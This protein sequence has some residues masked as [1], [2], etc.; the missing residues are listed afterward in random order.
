MLHRVTALG[1]AP[2]LLAQGLYVRRTIPRLPEPTCPREGVDGGGRPLRLLVAG[3]SAA[4]GVGAPTQSQALTGQVVHHLASD[5]QVDWRLIAANG[6]TTQ[7]TL[8]R[9]RNIPSVSID[10][11][12]TSLGVN[13]VVGGSSV[14]AWIRRQAELVDLLRGSFGAGQIL[15][16]G[17]PPVHA[18]PALPQPLR[19]YLG[20]Q[21][22]QLDR[23][24][25]RW[26]EPRDDC[27][28]LAL[29]FPLDPAMMAEDRFHP[30]PGIYALWGQAVADRIR[31][32]WSTE[33]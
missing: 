29:D 4:A 23:A 1:L 7:T 9:L 19:W 15:L 5:F 32:R 27:E 21:S 18:F 30:G 13:D 3:D 26:V 17:L 11:A 2:V 28:F 10:V 12:V 6:W 24:L 31:R 14:R 8:D 25:F 22:R 33:G 20:A 16:S